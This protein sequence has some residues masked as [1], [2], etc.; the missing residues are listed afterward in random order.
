MFI[1]FRIHSVFF[2]LPQL[3]WL[4]HK[5]AAVPEYAGK[6]DAIF[7]AIDTDN[8]GDIDMQKFFTA[9][10]SGS[11]LDGKYKHVKWTTQEFGCAHATIDEDHQQL[12]DLIN[13]IIDAVKIQNVGRIKE[14]IAGL[15]AYTVFHFTR[16]I[17]MLKQVPTYPADAL[18]KHEAAHKHFVDKVE[19]FEKG[20]GDGNLASVAELVTG[21]ILSFLVDWLSQHIQNTDMTLGEYFNYSGR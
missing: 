13:S 19:S 3:F 2:I 7:K 12:F 16:E 9:L 20:F 17:E 8:S 14:A 18:A 21:E 5:R 15:R 4:K 10:I 1:V 11:L 6:A